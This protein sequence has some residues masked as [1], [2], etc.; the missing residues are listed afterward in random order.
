MLKSS[1]RL[2]AV[3][4]VLKRGRYLAAFS[5]MAL[6]A[7]AVYMYT[8]KNSSINLAEPKIVFGLNAYALA[9]FAALSVLLSLSITLNAFAVSNRARAGGKLSAG[10]VIT[11][12]I[13]SSLCCTSVVPSVLAAFGASTSTILGVAGK[14]QG[15]LAAYETPLIAASVGLLLVSI[16]VVSGSINKKCCA[17]VK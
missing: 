12:I 8:A 7:S 15:P 6:L 4:F 2:G 17:V 14:I 11:S 16:F 5:V 10:A 13:P 1:S 9:V 3:L